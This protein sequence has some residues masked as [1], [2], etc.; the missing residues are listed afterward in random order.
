[1]GRD[2]TLPVRRFTPFPGK[3]PLPQQHTGQRRLPANRKA[4]SITAVI[5]IGINGVPI[6]KAMA[7]KKMTSP[8][9]STVRGNLRIHM[10]IVFINRF[11]D[12]MRGA[13]R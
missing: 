11:Y 12:R 3:P 1:M 2:Y 13:P 6:S 9:T 5:R 4:A 7:L 10:P 8:R